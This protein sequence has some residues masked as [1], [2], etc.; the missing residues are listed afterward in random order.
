[1]RYFSTNGWIIIFPTS[2]VDVAWR[3][4]LSIKGIQY[5]FIILQLT[6]ITNDF[7]DFYDWIFGVNPCRV[8]GSTWWR[9]KL[10][11]FCVDRLKMKRLFECQVRYFHL[12]QGYI[13]QTE[14]RHPCHGVFLCIS[15]IFSLVYRLSKWSH[16]SLGQCVC[17][18][19]IFLMIWT[20][21]FSIYSTFISRLLCVTLVYFVLVGVYW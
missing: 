7:Y 18:F 19:P 11:Q 10:C 15:F 16:A 5:R 12:I 4:P 9:L 8:G 21:L 20:R 13:F 14:G 6:I 1:M 3:I 17:M 2:T